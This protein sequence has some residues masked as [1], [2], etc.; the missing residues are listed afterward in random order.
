MWTEKNRLAAL[1]VLGIATVSL[2]CAAQFPTVFDWEDF[3]G[4]SGFTVWGQQIAY[5]FREQFDFGNRVSGLGDVNAD[6]IDDMACGGVGSSFATGSVRVFFGRSD[7]GGDGSWSVVDLNGCNGFRIP[8]VADGVR[9]GEV[10]AAGD[11]NADGVNDILVGASYAYP[12]GIVV[13]GEAYVIYGRSGLGASGLFD[14]TALDGSNGFRIQG[15][16][17]LGA[18]GQEGAHVGDVDG[19]GISDIMLSSPG[20]DPDGRINA[21]QVY[22]LY[23]GHHIGD[24]GTIRV[25]DAIVPANGLIINGV[26]A[27][28][29]AGARLG[30]AGDFNGDGY[31]DLLITAYFA[32]PEPGARGLVYLVYG[33]PDLTEDG[34]FELADLDGTN[35]FVIHGTSYEGSGN[36]HLQTGQYI[37]GVGDVNNDGFDDIAVT[38][39]SLIL[40]AQDFVAIVKGG[41]NVAPNGTLEL[42]DLNGEN[43]FAIV[44]GGSA[45]GFATVSSAGDLN[46]DGIDDLFTD[47]GTVHVVYG[48]PDI[49]SDGVIAMNELDGRDGFRFI[50]FDVT[51]VLA[52]AGDINNDGLSDIMA[53]M[54]YE[55]PGPGIPSGFDIGA[56]QVIFGRR[57]GDGDLDA[58]VDLADFGGFQACYGQPP[59]G[60][61]PDACH[62]FDFDK[63]NDVDLAD[64]EAFQKVF[65]SGV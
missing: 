25:P 54:E 48:S 10:H 9:S 29:K 35:G 41:T 60:D 16:Y 47:F 11:F 55:P 46:A 26:H 39:D 31:G 12:N 24:A 21:G 63:D 30:A 22:V 32:V 5:D 65:G 20:A 51:Y 64:F 40:G 3:D 53:G 15:V 43:G 28:D 61:V 8:G 57:M 19:D 18:L 34:T 23:G 2:P 36:H 4:R 37:T 62:P 14:L 1:T 7:I 56:M 59:D 58:D 13:A 49:G 38:G 52:C 6:G 50:P 17:P 33:G 42:E 44:R 27:G 45:A